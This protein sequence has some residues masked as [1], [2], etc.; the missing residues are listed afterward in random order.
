MTEPHRESRI[1]R[2]AFGRFYIAHPTLAGLAW[3]GT[4][5]EPHLDGLPAGRAQIAN[6]ETEEEARAY[7]VR[8]AK[9]ELAALSV[10]ALFST[11]EVTMLDDVLE[12]GRKYAAGCDSE[13]VRF[14]NEALAA[15]IARRKAEADR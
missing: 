9:R 3:S 13:E 6:F 15:E 4:S 8:E 7:Q 14:M 11:F 2:G 5:W 10:K 12:C 1:E